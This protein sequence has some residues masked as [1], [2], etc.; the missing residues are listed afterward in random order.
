MRGELFFVRRLEKIMWL[1]RRKQPTKEEEAVKKDMEA[2]EKAQQNEQGPD[3]GEQG[4][5]VPDE[6]DVE[7]KKKQQEVVKAARVDAIITE[8]EKLFI[9]E[10]KKRLAEKNNGEIPQPL[11]PLDVTFDWTLLRFLRARKYDVD[12]A[13]DQ[14]M[15]M[16]E[17]RRDAK[18]DGILLVP[19][20]NE[21]LFQN[22]CP[23]RHHGF[24]REGHPVYV[25]RTGLIRLCDLT[26]HMPEDEIVRRH[27]RYMES[28]VRRFINQSQ[29]MGEYLG[30]QV[31]IHDLAGMKY[32]IE[33]AGMRAFRQTTHIDQQYY[34]E[35]LHRMFIINAPLSFRAVWKICRPW[36]DA[37]TQ[38]KV[39]ILG[40]TYKDRLLQV[41][42]PDQLPELIGGQCKCEGKW[43]NGDTCLPNV[44]KPDAEDSPPAWELTPFQDVD[45]VYDP[46][47]VA[48]LR[49]QQEAAAAAKAEAQ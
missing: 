12:A 43:S 36:L 49:K 45:I 19:D 30:K 48:A 2:L 33:T 4:D 9:E 27:I 42:A 10:M 29:N 17:W 47:K 38:T 46:A 25:E 23:H 15:K 18:V 41:I 32:T 26:K 31:M 13:I 24:D 21:H 11:T 5:Y 14:Y 1:F 7:L 37:K 20:P 44:R 16:L 39:E 28:V 34:P 22:V 8:Q 40:T 35:C 3:A 6:V